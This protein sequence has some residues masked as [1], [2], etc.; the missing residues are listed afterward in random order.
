MSERLSVSDLLDDLRAGK[1]AAEDIPA[2]LRCFADAFRMEAEADIE[3]LVTHDAP[4]VRAA[5]VEVLALHWRIAEYRSLCEYLLRY[6]EDAGVRSAAARGLGVLLSHTR[7]KMAL[8]QLLEAARDPSEAR[9]V[10]QATYL[11]ALDVIGAAPVRR[12]SERFS[13]RRDVDW[14]LVDD[15]LEE[16][17]QV[18]HCTICG[19]P[20]VR[21]G[22]GPE[23]CLDCTL[24]VLEFTRVTAEATHRRVFGQD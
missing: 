3:A 2:V 6:D 21:P 24:D 7:D 1:F 22:D 5:A 4:E 9:R 18:R 17:G 23:W 19:A 14:R 20:M 16:S 15:L 8:R 11:A 10:R 12:D 13:L